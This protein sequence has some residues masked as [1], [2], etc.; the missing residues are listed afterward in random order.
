MKFTFLV[1]IVF[2]SF[3]AYS[4]HQF[5]L[6]AGPQ[7][8]DVRYMIEG[9]KQETN[10]KYGVNLGAVAKFHV[11][12]K[13]FFAPSVTYN[14]R[15]YD[16]K[17]SKPSIIPDPTATDNNTSFHTLEL[18]FPLQHDF[19]FDQNHWFFSLGPSLDIAL[20]GKE[21]YN[22]PTGYVERNM[23]FSFGD[24]GHYMFYAIAQLGFESKSGVFMYAHYNYSL[25]SMNNVDNGPKIGN[26]AAGI[27]IGKYFGKKLIVIDTR[28]KQ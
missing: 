2:L 27:T 3:S 25:T 8:T 15:G 23:K 7:I 16:V 21:K 11:E 19:S 26:R 24:Y 12:H 1:F 18:A 14:L 20:L 28:N 10:I 6:F 5:G 13:L 22:T 17:L 9:Q 4:Q